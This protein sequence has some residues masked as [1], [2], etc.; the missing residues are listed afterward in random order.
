MQEERY[1]IIQKNL[2]LALRKKAQEEPEL[3]ISDAETNLELEPVTGP[4]PELVRPAEPITHPYEVKL[5]S[6][7]F[8]FFPNIDSLPPV[9]AYGHHSRNDEARIMKLTNLANKKNH[10][11]ASRVF[12]STYIANI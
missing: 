2:E 3:S 5:D 1:L 12:G 7:G 8:Y 11:D 9:P 10:D 6:D 4:D